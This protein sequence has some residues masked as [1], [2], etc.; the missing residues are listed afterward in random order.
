M[1]NEISFGSWAA[2]WP[3]GG[4]VIP[5]LFDGRQIPAAGNQNFAQLNVPAINNGMDAAAKIAD[6]TQ[7]QQAWG[8]LD[9]QVQEQAATIP[10]R[11]LKTVLMHGSKI[12]G[13][14]FLDSNYSEINICTIGVTDTSV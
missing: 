10:M 3:S 13:N 6:P 4:S 7:A 14:V 2:D 12:G 9:Q 8:N 11:Y 5:P 1:Q